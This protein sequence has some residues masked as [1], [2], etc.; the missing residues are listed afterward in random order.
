M[1]NPASVDDVVARWR[2]LSEAEATVAAT[3]IDDAWRKLK[4]LAKKRGIAD[5]EAQVGADVDDLR[6]EVVRILAESV[7]RVLKN[8]DGNVQESIDD[9]A[10]TRN[11]D[12]ASGLLTFPDED[13]DDLFPGLAEAGRA[14]TVNPLA[15]YADRWS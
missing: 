3:L 12:V 2:P 14:F 11:L 7:L 9:Y 8:P 6:E 10:R 5:L 1:T 4:R 15:D 13:M